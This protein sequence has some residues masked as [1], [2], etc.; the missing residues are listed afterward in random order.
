MQSIHNLTQ[1]KYIIKHNTQDDTQQQL[2]SVYTMTD[3]SIVRGHFGLNE[4]LLLV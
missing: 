4:S 2:R 3:I 1:I